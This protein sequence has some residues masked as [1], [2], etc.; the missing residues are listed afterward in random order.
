MAV[1]S[2]S[3]LLPT[4]LQATQ[5]EP[6][7]V[8][9][10]HSF[11]PNFKPWSEYAKSIRTE[12]ERLSPWPLDVTEH[13]LIAAR[14]A[15]GN[16]DAAFAEYLRTLLLKDRLDLIISIGAPAAAFVQRHREDT[17]GTTPMIFTAVE[18]RRVQFTTL[19]ENDTV[20][21]VKHDLPAV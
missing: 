15:D 3:V 7:R 4:C 12:V 5:P 19:T 11:G 8:M 21:A 18:Q 1:I 10:L 9:L 6:K 17:F 14:F 16:T 20:V 2:A 13:S